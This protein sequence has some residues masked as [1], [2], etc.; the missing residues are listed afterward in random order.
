ML[1]HDEHR[2]MHYAQQTFE[3]IQHRKE[4]QTLIKKQMQVVPAL[5][6]KLKELLIVHQRLYLFFAYIF[7]QEFYQ[8][9]TNRLAV[10]TDVIPKVIHNVAVEMAVAIINC[11]VRTVNSAATAGGLS[12][13]ISVIC[14][15]PTR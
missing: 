9:N 11:C 3:Q 1:V 5:R 13:N 8:G 6:L 15:A 2:E 10:Q 4:V 7:P 12:A 14:G